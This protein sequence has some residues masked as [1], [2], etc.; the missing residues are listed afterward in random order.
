MSLQ[1]VHC[2]PDPR[3]WQEAG[4]RCDYGRMLPVSDQRGSGPTTPG[5]WW[6]ELEHETGPRVHGPYDSREEAE[7]WI[8][9]G[10]SYVAD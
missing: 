7:E 5:L 3:I 10:G 1:V 6:L 2:I 8:P 9:P 4:H